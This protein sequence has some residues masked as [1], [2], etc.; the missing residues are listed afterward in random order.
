MKI[1]RVVIDNFR[2]YYGKNILNL[3]TE[4]NK[5]IIVIGGRTGHGKT[6]LLLAMVWCLFGKRIGEIDEVFKKEIK[7]NNY[8]KFLKKSMN[9]DAESEGI[10]SFSVTVDF[11]EMELFT[12][13][14]IVFTVKRTYNILNNEEIFELLSDGNTF[15]MIN[16][17]EEKES[18]VND[19]LIPLKAA[20]FVFFDAEKISEIAEMDTKEQGSFMNDALGKILGLENYE[21]LIED[22]QIY[23]D[24]I[25]KESADQNI[26]QQIDSFQNQIDINQRKVESH[27]KRSSDI[28]EK[29]DELESKIVEYNKYLNTR[30][31]NLSNV[32][33][34]KLRENKKNLEEHRNKIE[35]EFLELTELI[36]F[37]I[38]AGKIQ[39]IIDQLN[40][41]NKEENQYLNN[42]DFKDKSNE[43][44]ESLF[45]Q[46]P[47]PPEGDIPLSKKFF[48]YNKAKELIPKIYSDDEL[49]ELIFEHD[50]SKIEIDNIYKLY[51]S[52]KQYSSDKYDNIFTELIKVDNELNTLNKEIRKIE[53]NLEDEVVSD[54][55]NKRDNAEKDII[56]LREEDMRNNITIENILK[57]N[58]TYSLRIKNLL[59][60]VEITKE[61]KKLY[62]QTHVFIKILNEFVVQE[63]QRKCESL[64]SKILCSIKNLMN[65]KLIHFVTTS[66]LPDNLGLQ[67]ELFDKNGDKIL[68]SSLSA[69]EKQ[70]FVSSLIKSI[71][72]ESI[73]ELPV[74]I[75]TP[76]GR[77]DIEH[78]ENILNNL[79][80]HL[81]N[82]VIIL[83]TN[84]EI[85]KERFNIISKN[86]CK[87]YLLINENN[88]TKIKAGYF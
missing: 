5:N 86:V 69:G 62:K 57:D 74:L 79:Y 40:Y 17:E 27:E 71:L 18:F 9:W 51:N 50:L 87:T 58:D 16:D 54:Y 48:Y 88:Q 67:I 44:I 15:E 14:N 59:E 56:D 61:K 36:P 13:N 42:E 4:G 84:D 83:S 10:N 31:L 39:E 45:N 28:Q 60:K 72:S 19:H 55:S 75:D 73:E 41:Q 47:Y 29:I 35:N 22:L 53:A 6:S 65:K 3:S 25:K 12:D 33:L 52:L 24:N 46:E 85:T 66:I 20:K 21:R 2:P 78:K 38:S 43:F 81:G 37:A 68:Q 30:G 80:P 77:L 11:S 70:L 82:Q 34:G 32:D 63:K 49:K 23:C 26:H 76:L 64:E 1:D 7:G 8:P